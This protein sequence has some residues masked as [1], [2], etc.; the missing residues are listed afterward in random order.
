MFYHLKRILTL[1]TICFLFITTALYG[2]ARD[3][4]IH[5]SFWQPTYHG[6]PL[7]YCLP[8]G[9]SC[10]LTV[11]NRYC[12]I[13]GYERASQQLIAYNVGMSIYLSNCKQKC[14]TWRCNGF[15]MINCAKRLSH[16]PAKPYHYRLRHFYYPRFKHY[17]IAWCYDGKTGCGRR[18]AFSFCRRIGYSNVHRYTIEKDIAATQAIGNKKLCFGKGC[19]AFREISCSR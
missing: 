10:G 6:L 12:R 11:A 17:R 5:R 18:A 9:R 1:G 3:E 19:D 15:K 16:H 2:A 14:T 4:I 13:L 8:D 7:N